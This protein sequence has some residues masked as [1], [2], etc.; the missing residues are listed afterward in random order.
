MHRSTKLLLGGICVASLVAGAGFANTVRLES[1]VREI[2]DK[3]IEESKRELAK[4]PGFTLLCDAKEL[5]RLESDS[6]PSPGIQGQVISAYRVAQ[7]S[8]DW[9]YL[10]AF[11]VIFTTA[12]PWAWYFFLRRVGELHD[13]IVGKKDA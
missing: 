11:L 4:F 13:A 12:I 5:V 1:K 3:C 10:L 7:E 6:N 9:P 2:E 8:R